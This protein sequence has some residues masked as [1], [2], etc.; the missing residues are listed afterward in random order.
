MD[1]KCLVVQDVWSVI[2]FSQSQV[3]GGNIYNEWKKMK[4]SVF[5][6]LEDHHLKGFNIFWESFFIVKFFWGETL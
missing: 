2:I 5:T 6:F 1:S 4:V 3:F